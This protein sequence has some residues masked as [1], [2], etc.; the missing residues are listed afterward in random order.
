MCELTGS[1]AWNETI[2]L[3]PEETNLLNLRLDKLFLITLVRL[4]LQY[5]IYA[6]LKNMLN[7]LS[8]CFL[9][10]IGRRKRCDNDNLEDLHIIPR[11][12]ASLGHTLHKSFV[13][14]LLWFM[15][16]AISI[17]KCTSWMNERTGQS[18]VCGLSV[19]LRL[20]SSKKVNIHTSCINVQQQQTWRSNNNKPYKI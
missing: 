5:H 13:L 3:R 9:N 19:L 14:I 20:T 17:H 7:F 2:T 16:F 18:T 8:Y 4:L 12:N 10:L 15:S 1:T 6:K 11:C